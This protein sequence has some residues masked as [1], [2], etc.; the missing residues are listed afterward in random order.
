MKLND[1]HI[2]ILQ[3]LIVGK[4]DGVSF[5]KL[6]QISPFNSLDGEKMLSRFLGDL[7]EADFCEESLCKVMHQTWSRRYKIT[8]KGKQEFYRSLSNRNKSFWDK[9]VGRLEDFF[10][11]MGGR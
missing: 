10:R 2:K 8:K 7:E 11:R 6:S 1:K 4:K 5:H 9:F 3:V